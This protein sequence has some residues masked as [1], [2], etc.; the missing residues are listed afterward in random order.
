MATSE[1]RAKHGMELLLALTTLGTALVQGGYFPTVFL[2]AALAAACGLLFTR[3]P[4]D[5]GRTWWAWALA[6]WYLCAALRWGYRSDSLAQAFLPAGCALFFTACCGLSPADR[7]RY[8]SHILLG[9]GALAVLSLLA[10]SGVLPFHGAVTAHRL[11]GTFQYANAAGSWF[12]AMALLA[13]DCPDA[14]CRKLTMVH[15]TALFLTRSTG[16]LALYAA[17]E[18]LRIFLRR[19]EGV[20]ADCVLQHGAALAFAALL[21]FLPGWPVL[22]ALALL[23]LLSWRWER[24]AA[25]GARLHLQWACLALGAAAAV[26]VLLSPRFSTSLGTFVERI[27]QM[28]DGLGAMLRHPVF[29]LG[30]GSWALLSPYYQSAQYSASV[31]HS[32]P[33]LIGVDAGLPAAALAAGLV[34]SGWRRGGRSLSQ[35]LAAALLILHSVLDFTMRFYPLATLLLALLSA[36]AGRDAPQTPRQRSLPFHRAGAA[37]CALL[38]LWLLAG[39]LE[40]KQLN[41]R[42]NAGD[43]AGAAACYQDRRWLFGDSRKARGAYL[44]ALYGAEDRQGVLSAAQGAQDLS[45]D[46]LLLQAQAMEELGDREGAC[47]LLLEQLEQRLYQVELFQATAERF[48]LWEVEEDTIDAYN[49]LADRANDSQTFLG[50]LKGDQVYIDKINLGGNNT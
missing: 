48:R 16:A 22:P 29:G 24:L 23:G 18:I 43:W 38:S 9:S 7:S 47:T 21:F 42:V 30:A 46:E 40:T 35:S 10:F 15:I 19:K 8:F 34:V 26:A 1:N 36:G 31:I 14:R 4:A 44:Y 6:G 28:K 13:Q 39:E 32:S 2:L 37:A 17:M 49:R 50:A 41:A 45:L 25:L 20:W 3:C 12:A 27:V 5:P 33:V 11:Q